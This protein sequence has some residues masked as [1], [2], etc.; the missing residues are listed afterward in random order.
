VR[1]Q[2]FDSKIDYYRVLGAQPTESMQ[3]LKMRYYKLALEFHPDKTQGKTEAKF[4]EINAAWEV[5]G[6]KE[7]RKQY[8]QTRRS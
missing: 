3:E 5:L 4:K 7:T 2:S 8:D 6:D 1:W